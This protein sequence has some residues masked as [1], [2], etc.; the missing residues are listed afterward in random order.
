MDLP[1]RDSRNRVGSEPVGHFWGLGL[2]AESGMRDVFT[3]NNQARKD[4]EDE[5]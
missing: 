1:P 4:Y 2:K 3:G 5:H